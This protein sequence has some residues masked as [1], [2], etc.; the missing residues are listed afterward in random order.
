MHEIQR[1]DGV[2][3]EYQICL[4][5]F[6]EHGDIDTIN[7]LVSLMERFWLT[8][9]GLLFN[10][11]GYSKYKTMMIWLK[12][13]PYFEFYQ[14]TLDGSVLNDS[15]V[16]PDSHSTE[17]L[18]ACLLANLFAVKGYK[19][20]STKVMLKFYQADAKA[21][22]KVITVMTK[23]HAVSE[24]QSEEDENRSIHLPTSWQ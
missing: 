9:A 19:L 23:L 20:L 8:G 4:K 16:F 18:A 2:Y 15:I 3:Q 10:L 6:P 21:S 1:E 22:R 7:P 24:K 14:R 5:H 13:A 12:H 11:H 17:A